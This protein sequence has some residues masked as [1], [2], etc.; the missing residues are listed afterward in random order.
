MLASKLV[1]KLSLLS[2]PKISLECIVINKDGQEES[3]SSSIPKSEF[4]GNHGILIRDLRYL[5]SKGIHTPV[6]LAKKK[7]L[8]VNLIYLRA[9]VEPEKAIFFEA[10]ENE[11]ILFWKQFKRSLYSNIKYQV[12]ISTAKDLGEVIGYKKW[13]E[14]VV[15][16]SMLDAVYKHFSS[17]L[18]KIKPQVELIFSSVNNEV[19]SEILKDA[20]FV[21]KK[22][23]ELNASLTLI[24]NT[25]QDLLN[26]DEDMSKM[27][28]SESEKGAERMQENH[29]EAELLLEHFVKSFD[30]LLCSVELMKNNI[31][32]A[33]A[34]SN[35]VLDS[36]R[37]K[38]LKMDLK[39]SLSSLCLGFSGLIGSFYGMNL[40][41]HLEDHKSA[42][43]IIA[44][45]VTSTSELIFRAVYKR[46][47]RSIGRF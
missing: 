38:I 21:S 23:E 30:E 32:M 14:F 24:R 2:Q 7:C 5:E 47:S 37:N 18:H 16:E 12:L 4:C 3:I 31:V 8:V 22:L 33:E 9:L 29:E 26:S 25:L 10:K 35:I 42:F 39:M 43:Y 15:L 19:T 20:L 11:N 17:E 1:R 45:S 34:I 40:I 13:F 44:A 46:I 36:Q 6:I 41:N 28:L 27:F